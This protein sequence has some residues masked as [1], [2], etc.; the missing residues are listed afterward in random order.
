MSEKIKLNLPCPKCN[1]NIYLGQETAHTKKGVY[2]LKCYVKV[3]KGNGV[4]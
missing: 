4:S 2:H 1:K 3:I